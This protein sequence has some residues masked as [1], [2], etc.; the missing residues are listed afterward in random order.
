MDQ[1]EADVINM[2]RMQEY[3]DLWRSTLWQG[4]VGLNPIIVIQMGV[5]TV[6]DSQGLATTYQ[7]TPI[8]TDLL[9]VGDPVQEIRDPE[10]SL[11]RDGYQLILEDRK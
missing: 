7:Q 6:K 4:T 8:P 1:A 5:W 3:L 10:D 9:R 2:T 11:L